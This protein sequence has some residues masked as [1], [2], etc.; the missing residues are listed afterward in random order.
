[1]TFYY[2]NTLLFKNVNIT[3]QKN[4]W[5]SFYG[6][7]GCG[8]TSLINLLL[9][10]LKSTSGTINYMGEYTNFDYENIKDVCS[11]ITATPELFDNTILYNITYGLEDPI[12]DEKIES[13]NKYIQL[14][15]LDKYKDLLDTTNI[16]TMSTGEKQRLTI[17]RMILI[18]KP[19]WFI[20]ESTSNI[21]NELEN[22]ILTELKNIQV[23]KN[24]SIIHITHNMENLQF[25][26]CKLCI[27]HNDIY[28][29]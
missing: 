19:I 18:D 6:N 4:K 8:K 22:I 21:D 10:K 25:S 24:K 14:F 7:S 15:K 23:I 1:M 28:Y 11:Y 16:N 3:L 26:D 17:I 29:M 20:D 27:K 13:M 2:D 9:S 12:S 5:I